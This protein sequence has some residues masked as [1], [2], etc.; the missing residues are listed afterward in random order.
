V[1]P[2]GGVGKNSFRYLANC[3]RPVTGTV[4]FN[5][6][7]PVVSV[8]T[9]LTSPEPVD[10]FAT[11]IA[12]VFSG[13]APRRMSADAPVIKGDGVMIACVV[14]EPF[15]LMSVSLATNNAV[16]PETGV[17]TANPDRGARS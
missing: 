10:G 13:I 11:A 9:R 7:P 5:T 14:T 16:L 2:V 17:T 15:R 8:R 1:N 3:P 4:A 6:I 12:V